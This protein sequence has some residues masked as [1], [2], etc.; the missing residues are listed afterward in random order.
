[1][2]K[3]TSEMVAIKI[4]Y[5][6]R[7]DSEDDILRFRRELSILKRVSHPNI[8]KLFEVIET[9]NECY[10]V[11]EYLESDLLT[12]IQDNDKLDEHQAATIILQIL[13]AVQYLHELGIC[14]RDIKPDNILLSADKKTVKLTDFGLSREYKEGQL[15]HTSC[16]S[17]C[18]VPP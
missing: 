14:H 8:V 4:M 11:M 5:K 3:L 17:P 9:E 15:L 2:H 6:N 18:F 7:F 13:K 16:G 1:M 12:Y 10:I